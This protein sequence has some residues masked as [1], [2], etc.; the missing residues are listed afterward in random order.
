[1][2]LPC[3]VTVLPHLAYLLLDI[4][5]RKPWTVHNVKEVPMRPWR[6]IL[7]VVVVSAILCSGAALAQTVQTKVADCDKVLIPP[8]IDGHITKIDPAQGKMTVR[9][10]DGTM[11]EFQATKETLQGY[12]PGERIMAK[13][14]QAPPC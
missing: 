10:S 12:K 4:W 8:T 2:T 11:H 14:R 6:N 9:A 3:P 1:M 5:L 13:L 7:A